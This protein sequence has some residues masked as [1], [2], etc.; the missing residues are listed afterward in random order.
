MKCDQ[1]DKKPQ[2]AVRQV[3]TPS[4]K[5]DRS[6]LARFDRNNT[7]FKR[8]RWDRSWAGYEHMYDERVPAILELRK[9]GYSRIDFALANASW[10]V[11]D[12][13]EAAFSQ[14]KIKLSK[15]PEATVGLDWTQTKL[16][17][18]EPHRMSGIVKRAARLFGA[19]LI[20]ICK[21]KKDWLY[22][23]AEVSNGIENS[24]VMAI[25]MN[26]EGIAT[27]PAVPAAAA[28]G[29]GYSRMAFTLACVA[30]F[31]RN[32]GYQA[33]QCGNDTALSIPLAVDAGLGELGRN[34]LLITPEFGPRVRLCKILTDIPLEPDKPIEFGVEAFCTKCKLCAKKCEA[35][36][37]SMDDNPNFTPVSSSNSP[38]VRK[39]YVN[40]ESCY[41]F[42]CKNG[43][44]C[45]TCI[46]V[47][48]YNIISARKAK[49][50]P[51]QFWN[52]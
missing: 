20:G 19:S 39:W 29:V 2:T 34:G 47:C 33:I 3:E 16:R 1:K 30:E 25:E 36:A 49:V 10:I 26:I 11:H 37:I 41:H 15:I 51:E 40:P 52:W 42:W 4:Y 44:D 7:V 31:L 35:N 8:V 18:D 32:L 22:A 6:K 5:L 24:I 43:T 46:R 27:S 12:S 45:S 38:G 23:D 14:E 21:L 13:Y 50:S 48:P 9:P 28:T 17:I